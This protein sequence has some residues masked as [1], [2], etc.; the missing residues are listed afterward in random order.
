MNQRWRLRRDTY[1]PAGEVINTR[2]YEIA[3][4]HSDRVVREFIAAHHY[5]QQHLPP[6]FGSVCTKVKNLPVLPYSRI[7]QMT[8][9]S[10]AHSVAL[11][12]KE[13]NSLV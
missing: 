5:L 8:A 12:S 6:D 2:A 11:Q 10:L 7:R 3:E 9:R 1:R 13:L 4:T